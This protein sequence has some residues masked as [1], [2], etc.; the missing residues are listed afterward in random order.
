MFVAIREDNKQPITAEE[1]DKLHRRMIYRC[2]ICGNVMTIRHRKDEAPYFI[3][4]GMKTNCDTFTHDRSQWRWEWMRKFPAKTYEKPLTLRVTNWE[5]EEAARKHGFSNH[6]DMAMET[7]RKK[8]PEEMLTMSHIAD[9]LVG[10]TVV[11][12][13]SDRFITP[14]EFNERCWFFYACGKRIVWIVDAENTYSQKRMKKI[15]KFSD[16][17]YR[18]EWKNPSKMF[19]TFYPQFLKDVNVYLQIKGRIGGEG[20]LIHLLWVSERVCE[21]EG[22]KYTVAD[23]HDFIATNC[24]GGIEGLLK[25]VGVRDKW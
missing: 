21:S 18:Y 2:P 19:S 13:V 6:L 15:G 8:Y 16:V 9:V 24:A 4:K 23:W 14:A 3:H 7:F 10:N 25:R 5:Y 20:E 1:A 17:K 12:F 11:E 22:T